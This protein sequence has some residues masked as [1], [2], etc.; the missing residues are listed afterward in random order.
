MRRG[1]GLGRKTDPAEATVLLDCRELECGL[2]RQPS[3]LSTRIEKIPNLASVQPRTRSD[4]FAV[5]IFARE[6]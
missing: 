1:L 4:K 3:H 6:P 2:K 5:Q